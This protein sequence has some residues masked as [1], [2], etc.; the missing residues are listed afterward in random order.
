MDHQRTVRC[1]VAAWCAT[2]PMG[3]VCNLRL[4]RGR[5]LSMLRNVL[6]RFVPGSLVRSATSIRC[7]ALWP[8]ANVRERAGAC[9]W[10]LSDD[11]AVIA[12]VDGRIGAIRAT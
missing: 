3:G 2:P 7:L 8:E 5:M 1:G 9:G 6:G 12:A 11:A 4:R 10:L